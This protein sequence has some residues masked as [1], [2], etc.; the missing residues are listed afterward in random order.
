MDSLRQQLCLMLCTLLLMPACAIP[1]QTPIAIGVAP[2]QLNNGGSGELGKIPFPLQLGIAN[3]FHPN[4]ICAMM[5]SPD[6]SLIASVGVSDATVNVYSFPSGR[7]IRRFSQAN[8]DTVAASLSPNGKLIATASMHGIITVMAFATGKVLQQWV[9]YSFGDT[10]PIFL[11]DSKSIVTTDSINKCVTV[12]DVSTGKELRKVMIPCKYIRAACLSP[13]GRLLALY[14]DTEKDS[15][16]VLVLDYQTLRTNKSFL[17]SESGGRSVTFS[18]DGKTLACGGLSGTVRM[19]DVAS[20]RMTALYKVHSR[21]VS[22]LAFSRDSTTL[23]SAAYDGRVCWWSLREKK[24]TRMEMTTSDFGATNLFLT[25]NEKWVVAASIRLHKWS[26]ANEGEKTT[27]QGH[28]SCVRSLSIHSASKL[29]ASASSDHTIRLWQLTSGKCVSVLRGHSGPVHF[30]S[31]FR[32]GKRLASI[33]RDGRVLV[34]DIKS[35]SSIQ[36]NNIIKPKM[37]MACLS[38]NNTV[39]VTGSTDGTI[40]IYD[41]EARKCLVSWNDH[42]SDILEIALSPDGQTLVTSGDDKSLR[43]Y[44]APMWKSVGKYELDD[45]SATGLLF[46]RDAQQLTF[47]V[48]RNLQVI[49]PATR[50]HLA[51]FPNRFSA[52]LMSAYSIGVHDDLLLVSNT[53]TITFLHRKDYGAAGQLALSGIDAYTSAY[54]NQTHSLLF[55]AFNGTLLLYRPIAAAADSGNR[56][57]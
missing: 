29:I 28:T 40:H 9:G 31:F 56:K 30:V 50:R 49:N 37:R 39:L 32:D 43:F 18:K 48:G 26:F 17:I 34:W 21:T 45:N 24:L 27:D 16:S 20:G 57:K 23:L 5:L 3:P 13:N 55:G 4:G 12:W 35:G 42:H 10:T 22:G 53:G 6:Q 51:T 7:F 19:W 52:P 46:S 2:K 11:P 8:T 54:D 14:C 38:A 1:W 36:V 41:I 33:G 47:S 44:S 15:S 25:K